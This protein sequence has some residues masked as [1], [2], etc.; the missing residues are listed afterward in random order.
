M[1]RY[2]CIWR[3]AAVGTV[4]LI[5]LVLS[6]SLAKSAEIGISSKSYLGAKEP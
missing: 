6:L 5:K 4:R 3:A 1:Q 2:L